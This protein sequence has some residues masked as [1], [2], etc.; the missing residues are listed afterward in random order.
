MNVKNKTLIV[1]THDKEILP[2]MDRVIN[3]NQLQGKDKHVENKQEGFR[4]YM[5]LY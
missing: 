5:S 4:N 2:H 3:L 1:I